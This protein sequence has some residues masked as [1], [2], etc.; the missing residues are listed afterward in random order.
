[1]VSLTFGFDSTATIVD[2]INIK[3]SEKRDNIDF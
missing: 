1:M 3:L 2:L